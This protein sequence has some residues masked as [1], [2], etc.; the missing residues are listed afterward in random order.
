MVWHDLAVQLLGT[1][2]GAGVGLALAMWWDRRKKELDLGDRRSTTI[3]SLYLEV[4]GIGERLSIPELVSEA[5]SGGG[6][7]LDLPRPHLPNSAFE[8][9]VHSGNLTLLPPV[10]QV[11][12]SWCY[13]QL[14]LARLIVDDIVTFYSKGYEVQETVD[15]LDC[16][17][18]VRGMERKL[19]K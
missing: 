3:Q 17:R 15:Y 4:T 1:L 16:D 7:Q 6:A 14:R 8:A 12:L 18:L 13:E 9:A 10:L 19:L 2:V 5:L 11:E